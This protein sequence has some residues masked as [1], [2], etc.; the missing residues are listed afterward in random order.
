[1]TIARS[2]EAA[3]AAASVLERVGDE[4]GVAWA[5]RLIANFYWWTGKTGEAERVW[6]G[7]LERAER[8]SPR[9]VIDL[10]MWISWSFWEGPV[11]TDEGIRR[12]DEMI[13]RRAG[14]PL[15]EGN[16]LIMRGSLNAMRAD[17][18]AARADITAGRGL[19][20][21]IGHHHWW[22]GTS[23][24]AADVELLAGEPQ[25]AA[26]VLL[27]GYELMSGQS[28][29]GYLATVVGMRAHAAQELGHD[30][31]AL[32]LADETLQL[33]A[34]DDFE[35]QAR[36]R[37]IRGVV[38]AKRGEVDQADEHLREAE[39]IASETDYLPFRAMVAMKRAEAA[40]F[41]GRADEERAALEQALSLA[42]QKRDLT[43]A[44]KAR[45]G[46]AAL[47]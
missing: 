38:L 9:L 28:A 29:T 35:P 19:L 15:V 27:E 3:R 23:M 34:K 14:N 36:S 44:A 17:F 21:E 4:E 46:L 32:R 11:P 7:A 30:E 24:V 10:E 20:R 13:A 8:V 31:E 41:L 26:D 33:A 2:F 47:V 25:A 37:C 5:E 22:A 12:C 43:T 18:E 6:A 42:E 39:R 45:A 1:M 40:R 16:V